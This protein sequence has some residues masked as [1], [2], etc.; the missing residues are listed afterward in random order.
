L[1]DDLRHDANASTL[2][3]RLVLDHLKQ[4]RGLTIDSRQQFS[5]G[6]TH[7]KSI[8]PFVAVSN[9]DDKYVRH[10]HGSGHGKSASDGSIGT[11]KR[12]VA[13]ATRN[14]KYQ[15]SGA[16]SLYEYSKEHLEVRQGEEECKNYLRHIIWVPSADIDR[17]KATPKGLPMTRS[18]HSI[19]STG[20]AGQI[21]VRNLSCFCD[22]CRGVSDGKC[23]NS[24]HVSPWKK[25]TLAKPSASKSLE[26]SKFVEVPKFPG[27]D[28]VKKAATKRKAPSDGGKKG[29]GDAGKKVKRPKMIVKLGLPVRPSP[30]KTRSR[31]KMSTSLDTSGTTVSPAP[32][33]DTSSSTPDLSQ[34]KK[35]VRRSRSPP[36]ISASTKSRKRRRASSPKSSQS[37]PPLAKMSSASTI[38]TPPSSPVRKREKTPESPIIP[39]SGR[40]YGKRATGKSSQSPPPLPRMPS[41]EKTPESP[42]IPP[43]GRKYGTR[44]TGK[45]S[46]SPPPL[47]RMPSS[48]VH[49]GTPPATPPGSP[50]K[51]SH[52]GVKTSP[53]GV[54]TSPKGVKTSPKRFFTRR[55]GP[56][57]PSATSSSAT[58]S[59]STLGPSSKPPPSYQE[60]M[61]SKSRPATRQSSMNPFLVVTQRPKPKPKPQPVLSQADIDFQA[62]QRYFHRIINDLKG[63]RRFPHVKALCEKLKP[64]LEN[65][66]PLDNTIHTLQSV[67]VEFD[68]LSWSILPSDI[69]AVQYRP[70]KAYGDG[71][72]LARSVSILLFGHEEFFDEV[73]ARIVIE[74]ILNEDI[75][76]DHAY[77]NIDATYKNWPDITHQFVQY[78]PKMI[79][80]A[81]LNEEVIRKVYRAEMMEVRRNGTYM[82]IWQIIQ[83][84]N[85]MQRSL[86]IV[87]PLLG[88]A[89]NVR[90]DMHRL[91]RPYGSNDTGK[92]LC[93]IMWSHAAMWEGAQQP[94]PDHFVPLVPV[95]QEEVN[96]HLTAIGP[97]SAASGAAPMFDSS[98]EEEIYE[99]FIAGLDYLSEGS[100]GSEKMEPVGPVPPE[101]I[102][103]GDEVKVSG[104]TS[105]EPIVIEPDVEADVQ[106]DLQEVGQADVQADLQEVRQ[107]DV[108]A[109]LQVDVQEVRQV[110]GEMAGRTTS[111]SPSS[112]KVC[113]HSNSKIFVLV[114]YVRL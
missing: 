96:R 28:S 84:A 48:P 74:G 41:R 94:V 73:R 98:A 80:G 108:Q 62:R 49:Y 66:Y 21:E 70:V 69:P 24:T 82:G 54:K 43:S 113:I 86:F 114:T 4:T 35:G 60:A 107:A 10:Y 92:P 38:G 15:P 32:T 67:S 87:Y 5:D 59:T 16:K 102:M 83:A 56:I 18:L 9:A 46:Q 79:A 26:F 72:C 77:L 39:P 101:I 33:P 47:P 40:R 81:K 58:P 14:R 103:Q 111:I 12:L 61:K 8:K 106:A 50:V 57:P 20:T 76:L 53:K 3:D 31:A 112:S 91:I 104:E 63:C 36:I 99:D 110:P 78:S 34:G 88:Y 6:A 45:S 23:K 97:S 19:R 85:F 1:T 25:V 51:T 30:V 65:K 100:A 13:T 75:Y 22:I 52:K 17:S 2:F 90:R 95:N 7:F 109:D 105:Q 11:Y 64:M 42:I 89:D 68:E 29:K 55:T 27:Q 93:G 71:N 37:P 44:A